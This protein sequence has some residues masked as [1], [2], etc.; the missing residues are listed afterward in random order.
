MAWMSDEEW[1]YK[2]DCKDKKITARS[3]RNKRT[4]NGKGG[5]VKLPSDYL[6][7]K[8]LKAMNGPVESYRMNDPMS[9]EEFKK[10]PDD[11]KVTYIKALR[12]KY[13][14][15]DSMLADSMGVGRPVFS[16]YMKC[17]GLSLGS[18]TANAGRR[19]Y[20]TPDHDRFVAWWNG[21]KLET[22]D[23]NSEDVEESVVD[24]PVETVETVDEPVEPAD[25]QESVE[26]S[27]APKNAD[28]TESRCETRCAVPTYG[29]MTFEGNIDDI[30]R[31]VGT[32][33]SGRN[34]HIKVEWDLLEE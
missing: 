1:E 15:P 31:S 10:L 16:K 34:V 26:D 21:V 24:I 30:L 13:K 5:A 12:E 11:L 28:K 27:P 18:A 33:L 9:W 7:K 23:S 2:Q 4:H 19:W 17:Y 25:V 14:V 20:N 3:A 22:V 32:L 29:C 8:E 6:S